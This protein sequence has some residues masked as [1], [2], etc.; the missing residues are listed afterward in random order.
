MMPVY[1]VSTS[2][3]QYITAFCNLARFPVENVYCTRLNV[4][5]YEI[6]ASETRR[7]VE[8]SREI[9][10]MPLIEIRPNTTSVDD[11]P[12]RDRQTIRRLD[13][14]FWGEIPNMSVGRMITETN[15]IGGP[16]KTRAVQEIVRKTNTQIPDVIYIGD[17]I[18]DVA[19]FHFVREKGGLTVSFNGNEYAIR[20]A[21]IAVLST[22]T[23][24]ISILADVFNR[25][26][27]ERVYRMVDKWDQ[28]NLASY[29]NPSLR[30]R[31]LELYPTQLPVIEPITD[32]NRARLTKE[33]VAFRKTVRGEAVG[34]LG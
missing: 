14:L 21:E 3:E 2:Y 29:V 16:Q 7:L 24:P 34:K 19:P 17:S 30:R 23:I 32:E 20:E 27:K 12:Q 10:D 26:G 13:D 33:S 22:N 31:L 11:F 18:T 4:D 6:N 15:P 25:F 9:A 8:I 5:E 28:Q 1:I